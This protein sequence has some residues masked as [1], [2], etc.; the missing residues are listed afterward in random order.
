[1]RVGLAAPM[2]SAALML[3]GCAP[4]GQPTAPAT[5]PAPIAAAAPQ[6]TPPA[7]V[8][9]QAA[10][11]RPVAPAAQPGQPAPPGS[12]ILACTPIS[13]RPPPQGEQNLAQPFSILLDRNDHPLAFV[14]GVLPARI[15]YQVS[16]IDPAGG[17]PQVRIGA[18]IRYAAKDANSEMRTE[19]AIM[20]DN[21]YRLGLMLKTPTQSTGGTVD[22]AHGTCTSRP[23]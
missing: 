5:P 8:P 13:Q 2:I 16:R 11:P 19:L 23:A 22:I 1:M 17:P 18:I 15:P 3:A 20:K 7:A 14:G 6:L 4:D 10:A 9:P 12:V 21:T